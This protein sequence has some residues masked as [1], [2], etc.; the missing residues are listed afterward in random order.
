[1]TN[2]PM[3]TVPAVNKIGVVRTAPASIAA[4]FN[5]TPSSNLKLIKSM[6]NTELRTIIPAKAIIPIN[7]VAVKNAPINQ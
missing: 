3:T 5:G 6:S 1:M 2:A 4:C 7:D